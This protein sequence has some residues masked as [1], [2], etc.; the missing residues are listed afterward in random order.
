MTKQQLTATVLTVLF[1]KLLYAQPSLGEWQNASEQHPVD[2][3]SLVTN[4]SGTENTRAWNR[5]SADAAAGYNKNNPDFA[6]AVYSGTGIESWYWTPQKNADLIWQDVN[7]LPGKYR[8][9][10]FVTAQ[11]YNDANRKGQNVG[12]VCLRSGDGM[13]AYT[14]N[15]WDKVIAT[16]LVKGGEPLR[17]GIYAGDD[18]A[19]DWVSIAQV[20]VECLGVDTENVE[21]IALNEKYDVCALREPTY[22]DLNLEKYLPAGQWTVLTL[23]CDLDENGVKNLFAKVLLPGKL[24]AGQGKATL[25]GI[26]AST[27]QA[28]KP[29]LV[30]PLSTMERLSFS[31]VMGVPEEQST[32]VEGWVPTFRLRE[33]LMNC[34]TLDTVDG[35]PVLRPI[36][37]N[38]PVKGFGAYLNAT[39]IPDP[40][41]E[42]LHLSIVEH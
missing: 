36:G 18:N 23:P 41:S 40:T 29:Y 19:N 35:S 10:A 37:T 3:T 1:C 34:Y 24:T 22:A 28:G 39:S 38:E 31:G 2:V 17:I 14:N 42:P 5:H 15:K 12:T 13:T 27:M 7:V 9:T 20:K 25:E 16:G 33:G 6:S 11:V 26:P 8:V 30:Q 21:T 4:A 32:T